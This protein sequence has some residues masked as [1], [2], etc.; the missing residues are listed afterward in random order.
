MSTC[1]PLSEMYSNAQ[2]AFSG[3]GF[4]NAVRYHVLPFIA[5]G[6]VEYDTSPS[7]DSATDSSGFCSVPSYPSVHFILSLAIL[8][9]YFTSNSAV[10]PSEYVRTYLPI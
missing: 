6:T 1:S 2:T 9:P 10:S 3:C 7:A 4:L 8:V 5:L